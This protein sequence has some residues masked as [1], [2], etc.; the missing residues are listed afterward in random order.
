[1]MKFLREIAIFVLFA[2]LAAFAQ[3]QSV[4]SVDLAK[5]E[6]ALS[7][8]SGVA[9]LDMTAYQMSVEREYPTPKYVLASG[10]STLEVLCHFRGDTLVSCTIYQISGATLAAH[11]ATD[12]LEYAKNFLA[13]YCNYSKSVYL[14]PILTMI[15]SVTELKDLTKA[16]GNVSLTIELSAY[17]DYATFRWMNT[18]N[19]IYNPYNTVTLGVRDGILRSFNEYWNNYPVGDGGVNFSRTA[20][21]SVVLE[22]TQTFSYSVGGIAVGNL[23]VSDAPVSAELTMQPRNGVLYPQWEIYLP[24]DQVYPGNVYSIHAAL[25]ADTGEIEFIQASSALGNLPPDGSPSPSASTE[26]TDT[27]TAS[28]VLSALPSASPSPSADISASPEPT[29]SAAASASSSLYS[30]LPPEDKG[31]S[32]QNAVLICGVVGVAVA[33]LVAMVVGPLMLRKRRAR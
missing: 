25:W 2:L 32:L 9:E 26:P 30:T 10:A 14:Q 21:V 3:I 11:P 5:Q 8:F 4:N 18:I 13:R 15:N 7:F 22:R 12:T 27:P 24:L 19:G 31:I 1:M 33:A 29:T 20:A 28:P 17:E 16:E 6:R 23:T